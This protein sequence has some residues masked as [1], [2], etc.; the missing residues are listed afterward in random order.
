VV[1]CRNAAEFSGRSEPVLGLPLL[2]ARLTGH[3]PGAVNVSCT[4]LLDDHGRLR[5][6]ED[7]KQAFV[8]QGVLPEHDVA[9][10]C[11]VGGR[12]SLGWFV[13]HEVLGYPR[14]RSYDGGWAEYGSL[15]GAPVER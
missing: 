8:S 13:L 9:V 14:V 4:G 11:D 7:L 2:H 10:Y 15:V 1:D 12:G 3:I 5:P 6:T